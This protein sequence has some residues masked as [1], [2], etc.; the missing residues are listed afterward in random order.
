M[1]LPNLKDQFSFEMPRL[2]DSMRGNRLRQ[3]VNRHLGYPQSAGG[4]QVQH[5]LKMRAIPADSRP[6]RGNIHPG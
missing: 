2:A 6:Q 4:K 3:G 1:I 5:P